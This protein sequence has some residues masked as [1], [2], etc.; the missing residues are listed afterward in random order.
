[1]VTGIA[2]VVAGSWVGT[3]I[4]SNVNEQLFTRLFKATLTAGAV[5]VVVT[6]W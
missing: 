5:R 6:A 1:M 2:A 4:L 3:R